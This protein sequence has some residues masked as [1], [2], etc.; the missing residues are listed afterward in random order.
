SA[1]RRGRAR[2]RRASEMNGYLG[3]WGWLARAAVSGLLVLAVGSPAAG[4]WRQPGGRARVVVL[5]FLRALVGPGLGML[6]V[7][8]RGSTRVDLAI[9]PARAF[10][11]GETPAAPGP[12][13]ERVPGAE[14]KA[15]RPVAIEPGRAQAP[16]AVARHERTAGRERRATSTITSALAGA[17]WR[18]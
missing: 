9:P 18:A 6:A 11:R 7:S 17:P 5:T 13:A 1:R 15:A 4:L 10:V 14:V 3:A 8:P 2:N 16:V 12:S